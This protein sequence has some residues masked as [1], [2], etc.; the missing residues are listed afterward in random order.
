MAK[1][2]KKTRFCGVYKNKANN[3]FYYATRIKDENGEY[4]SIKSKSIY[5]SAILA[6]NALLELKVE[7]EKVEQ[8]DLITNDGH[9]VK[10]KMIGVPFV[11]V[12]MEWL[13][14]Y[15][16]KN[17]ESTTY[18]AK[19]RL[20]QKI[21]PFFD[22]QNI[23]FAC[24]QRTLIDFKT[25]LKNAKIGNAYRN[26]I[27]DIYVGICQHAF[28]SNYI[29]QQEFGMVKLTLVK[30][31]DIS[32]VTPS[33]RK[34][35]EKFFYSLEEFNQFINVVD[36][37]MY[38]N[39]Y[40]MLFFGGFRINE[41]LALKVSD[42]DFATRQAFVYKTFNIKGNI[43]MPKT[44]NSKRKVYLKKSVINELKDYIKQADLKDDDLIFETTAVTVR[45]KSIE[46]AKIA[47]VPYL[48]PHGF[49]HSCCSLLF[50]T[51]KKNNL[52]I[53][54]KAVA[55]FLGD[56]VNTTLDVYYHLYDTERTQIVDL[57]E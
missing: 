18:F 16:L 45:S 11:K 37:L 31:K 19:Q 41:L 3:M 12:A 53:D 42:I 57:I 33:K 8:L 20:Q 39:M 32:E 30:F 36:E 6:Y 28:Y 26:M 38:Y 34:K 46:Y 2:S 7:P 52:A 40:L 50:E 51:Y 35:R 4:K 22:N 43:T 27:M 23:N 14:S 24:E 1:K 5:P 13:D 29:N 9:P 47:G 25:Q 49:R 54:F 15:S 44:K 48:N 21:L 55:D 10:P 17:K 56:K